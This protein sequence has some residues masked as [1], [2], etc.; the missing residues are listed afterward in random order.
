MFSVCDTSADGY[1]VSGSL[2]G[3]NSAGITSRLWTI[4]D[5]GD[6][7]CDKKGENIGQLSSYQMEVWWQMPR[8]WRRIRISRRLAS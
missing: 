2:W 3:S 8:A 4:D 6:S 7:G 5:G 1:G